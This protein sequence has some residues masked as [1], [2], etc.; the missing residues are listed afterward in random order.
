MASL[1]VLFPVIAFSFF[2]FNGFTQEYSKVK[3]GKVS[4]DDFT[5][6]SSVVDNSTEAVVVSD[7]GSSEF[8]GNM[9]SSFSIVFTRS[10]RI[11]ILD[12]KGIDAATVE[13]PLYVASSGEEKLLNLKARTY[14]LENG[15]VIEADLDKESVFKEKRNKNLLITKF[16]M[17]AVK[18]GSIIEY[19]YTIHSDFIFNLQPWEFQG[20]YP[21]LWSEY[22]VRIPEYFKYV[23]LSQGSKDFSFTNRTNKMGKWEVSYIIGGKTKSQNLEG[24]III[25]RW[26]MKDFPALKEEP[27]TST[28]NNHISK[29]QFQLATIEYPNQNAEQI[30]STWEKT[31]SYLMDNENFGSALKQ[32]NQWLDD[33][34]KSIT[35]G[36]SMPEVKA[37]KIFQYVKNN[38]TSNG[39]TGLFL[40]EN[41]KTVFKNKQGTVAE[42]NLLLTSMLLH[43]KIKA[44]PLILSTKAHGY[45]NEL[46]PIL[47]KFNYVVCFAE[48]DE[49]EVLLDA[50]IPSLAF[51]Q[52]HWKCYNGHSRIVDPKNPSPIELNADSLRERKVTIINVGNDEKNEWTGK[53]SSS[54]GTFESI[55]LKSD[56]AEKGE[57]EYFKRMRS[58]FTYD[59][60]IHH[61][62]IDSLR[63]D[64]KPVVIHYDFSIP[65]N[66]DD[67]L[68]YFDPLMGNGYKSNPFIS[69]DRTYPVEMPFAINEAIYVNI[70]APKGYVIDEFPKS[71]KVNLNEDEGFFEYRAQKVSDESI[72]LRSWLKLDR[73]NF[74][75]EEYQVL[76]EFYALVV[77]KQAELIVFKKKP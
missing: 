17:P 15:K 1:K 35:A 10:T 41:L 55:N 14:N 30:M 73:A 6:N 2:C 54:L 61:A 25:D 57:E 13:I 20:E 42:I 68:I 9:K 58:A 63:K 70:T 31:M 71:S 11:L 28:V 5:I 26:V 34:L 64:G 46:Y 19:S 16:T 23:F 77:R 27:F 29:I 37:R 4:P 76:R 3:Y 21:R 44:Y 66:K 51:G 65:L 49:N 32:N 69:A 24:Q 12:K 40:T 48:I 67:N 36:A 45:T 38:F 62:G 33:E 22:E 7:I 52:L 60:E 75:P 53:F 74:Y 47:E 18:P 39:R 8:V 43:E 50:S 59:I 72:Q 56:I